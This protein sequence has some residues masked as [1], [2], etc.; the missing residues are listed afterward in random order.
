[1]RAADTYRGARRNLCFRVQKGVWSDK[2]YYERHSANYSRRTILS[3]K[4]SRY[5]PM[6]EMRDYL[7]KIGGKMTAGVRA[8]VK[9]PLSRVIRS[10]GGARGT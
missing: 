10:R 3:R 5:H 4:P 8:V 9:S 1:M 2:W 7:Q 6:K